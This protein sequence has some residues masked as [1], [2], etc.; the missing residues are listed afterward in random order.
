ML[1]TIKSYCGDLKTTIKDEEVYTD[2]TLCV[3]K[4]LICRSLKQSV[5]VTLHACLGNLTIHLPI[6]YTFQKFVRLAGVLW[7]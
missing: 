6:I 1:P 7:T 5:S 2:K 3:Y 4:S